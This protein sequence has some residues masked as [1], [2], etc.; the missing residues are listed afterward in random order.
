MRTW[1][2]WA[3]GVGA[4]YV[5]GGVVTAVQ[6]KRAQP[7]RRAIDLLGDAAAWPLTQRNRWHQAQLE[8][9]AAP[10]LALPVQTQTPTE[11][12]AADGFSA[13]LDAARLRALNANA[14][15]LP[16]ALQTELLNT[17][18]GLKGFFS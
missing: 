3:C 14:A 16:P 13:P 9:R 7:S 17:N 10:G 2:K 8:Q 4:A 11:A 15:A 1:A 12:R 6:V 5:M 18:P